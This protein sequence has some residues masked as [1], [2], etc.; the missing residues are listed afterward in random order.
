MKVKTVPADKL[1]NF[2]ISCSCNCFG[3]NPTCK[4]RFLTFP[5]SSDCIGFGFIFAVGLGLTLYCD[6]PA[7]AA[8]CAAGF[9]GFRT[10]SLFLSFCKTDTNYLVFL[11]P[12]RENGITDKWIAVYS[13]YTNQVNITEQW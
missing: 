6:V 2:A 9:V 11:Q 5:F 3:D 8:F 7:S 4:V 13:K 1:N 10:S 12:K